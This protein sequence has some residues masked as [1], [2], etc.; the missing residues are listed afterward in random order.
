MDGCQKKLL[1]ISIIVEEP[2]TTNFRRIHII[3]YYSFY[4]KCILP[5]LLDK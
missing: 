1:L 4:F 3:K 5:F 2:E